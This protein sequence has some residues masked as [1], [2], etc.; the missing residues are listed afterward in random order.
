MYRGYRMVPR[1]NPETGTPTD[2]YDIYRGNVCVAES[3]SY[4]DAV[5]W[6]ERIAV[7]EL[8][9]DAPESEGFSPGR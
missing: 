9:E 6:V 8:P 1:I 5:L 3:L 2:L 4:V 7:E